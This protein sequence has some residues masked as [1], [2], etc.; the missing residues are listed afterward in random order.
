MYL[1]TAAPLPVAPTSVKVDTNNFC[2]GGVPTIT[3]TAIGG[4]GTTLNWFS[5]SCGGT[6][7]GSGTPL[8][9]LAPTTT[10]A[11]YASWTNAC[12]TSSCKVVVVVVNPLPVPSLSGP[13]SVCVATTGNVY[14]TDPG[15][16]DYIWH[17]SAG[18]TVTA[19]G[20]TTSDNIVITWTIPGHD[21]VTVNYEDGNGCM[22]SASIVYNVLVNPLPVPVITGPNTVCVGSTVIYATDTAMSAYTWNSSIGGNI[23]A[24]TGTDSITVTWNTAGPQWVNVFYT[25]TNGCTDT[26]PTIYNVMVDTV[27][28]IFNVTGGGTIC[29]NDSVKIG[30]DSSQAGMT[31][32][33]ILNAGPTVGTISGTGFPFSFG[34]FSAPGTYIVVA[35]NGATGC[36]DTMNG[37]AIIIVNP[38]PIPTITGIDTACYG[39]IGDIYKTDTGMTN[40]VWTV[41]GGT[42]TAGGTAT[43]DSVVVT[44]N[45]IGS[46]TIKVNYTDTNGCKAATATIF[47]VKVYPLPV[48][49][50]TGPNQVCA[51][52]TGNIYATDTGMTGYNWYVSSGGSIIS[53]S[54]TDSIIVTWNT[55]GSDTVTVNYINKHGCTDTVS[56]I[57]L[58][59]VNPLPIK[60]NV[61]GSATICASDSAQICLSN[62][63]VGVSYNLIKNDAGPSQGSFNGNGSSQCFGYYSLPGIYTV[64]ATN[65]ITGCSDT[66]NGSAII[67]VNPLPI[68]SITGIDTACY[69]T[70]GDI[71][72]T[73]TG[74]S[75]YVWTVIGG[76]ITAG[77]TAT[78]DSVVVTWNTV[79]NDTVK[80]NYTNSNGCTAL[81]PTM[82]V[83]KV[84]SLPV[85]TINGPSPVCAGTAGNIYTTDT[86]MTGYI[87]KISG[88]T[89]IAGTGTDSI[90]ITWN[91]PGTDTLWVNY[92]DSHGCTD[93]VFAMYIVTVDPLPVAPTLATVDTNNFCKGT[94]GNI[95]LTSIGGSGTTLNWSTSC[96]GGVIGSGSPLTIAAPDSTTTY[97]A[98]WTNSCGTSG[99]DSIT[100][101]VNPLPTPTISGPTSVCAGSTGNVYTTQAGMIGY[102]WNI[103]AGG[104]I[105]SGAATNS[106][107]VTWNT[108]GAQTISVNDSN[109]FGCTAAAATIYNVVVH[110]LPAPTIK[111]PDTICAGSTNNVYITQSGESNYVWI[112][113]SGGTKTAGGTTSDSTITITW[114]TAG[115]QTISVNYE[116]SFGCFDTVPFIYHEMVNPLPEDSITFANTSSCA[117]CD[118]SVLVIDKSNGSIPIATYLWSNGSMYSS[119]LE[120]CPSTYTVTVTTLSGCEK[121]NSATVI[122]GTE[123][124]PLTIVNTFSPNGDNINDTW[125]IKNIEL[126]PDNELTVVNRWGNEVYHVKGY[127]SNWDGSNLSNGTYFYYLKVNMCGQENSYK[128]YVTIVR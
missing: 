52:T 48:P 56:T 47:K 74:M 75:N 16:S 17:V 29:A 121:I 72:R 28:T 105:T 127:Q 108:V 44:W 24:G 35:L 113:S 60:Y 10:T 6:L 64:V 18:G 51:G 26:L 96:G 124:A 2:Y 110:T 120:L 122:A 8:I 25:D 91:V 97:Y 84:Y 49:I 23:I 118:G 85:P 3:L 78:S 39:T 81:V 126:Y 114:D 50:I 125:V 100:V 41:I 76:T 87:W 116:N 30:L 57:Y 65:S 67:I 5:G 36:N 19:W 77:G 37:N 112:V 89:I 94:V 59:T 68:P 46:D 95:V 33:L 4:S 83:V 22:D 101:V 31:Y 1:V 88:G 7:V 45:T 62:S 66:M 80:V 58:V 117:A 119:I 98:S 11:Y 115:I 93:T 12:G 70:S 15:M 90:N 21:T 109:S 14:T 61:T 53:G 111:G 20:S 69:G 106:I 32:N 55:A 71:Y 34:Y 38:L 73:D 99:C 128:G 27:P 42:I 79:G 82:Y 103:S 123:I 13:A 43:S 107:T 54:G 86:G 102:T 9:I 63:Q 104:V 40:Y 92:I